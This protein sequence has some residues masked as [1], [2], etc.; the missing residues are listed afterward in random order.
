[1]ISESPSTVMEDRPMSRAKVTALTA[2][3]PLQQPVPPQQ[4][5][6][7]FLMM[8]LAFIGFTHLTVSP[9]SKCVWMH[10]IKLYIC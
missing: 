3:V 2:Q 7:F 4:P 10:F 8:T 5:R 1:M 6:K 9:N